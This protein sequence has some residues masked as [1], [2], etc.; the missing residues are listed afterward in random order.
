MRVGILVGAA[1]CLAACPGQDPT[2]PDSTTT[3]DSNQDG[4]GASQLRLEWTTNPAIQKTTPSG[5]RLDDIRFRMEN[6]TAKVDVDPFDPN[7]TREELKLHWTSEAEPEALVFSDPPA[8]RY[9]SIVLKLDEGEGEDAFELRGVTNAGD[10]FELEDKA[11]VPI[12]MTCDFVLLPRESKTLI[13][14]IDLSPAIDAVDIEQLEPGEGVD[15]H[16][17]DDD[18]VVLTQLRTALQSAFSVRTL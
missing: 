15:H 10:T 7:L 2:S 17:D 6:V 4:N 18:V 16:L 9:T 12:S 11:T 3:L 5:H 13:V 8:G 1:L 14:T